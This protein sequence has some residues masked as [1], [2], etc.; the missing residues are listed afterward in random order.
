MDYG[1]WWI[2]MDY[3]LSWIIAINGSYHGLWTVMDHCGFLWHIVD[4]RG[5]LNTHH[6]RIAW[7][8][9]YAPQASD[10]T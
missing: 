10:D 1:L 5:F 7:I 6:H 4:Y 3:G 2:I 8:T 9:R